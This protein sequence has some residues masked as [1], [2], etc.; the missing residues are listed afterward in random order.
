MD[1]YPSKLILSS[2]CTNQFLLSYFASFLNKNMLYQQLI[3]IVVVY[4]WKF[5]Q[6]CKST[7]KR[8]KQNIT[9]P[10]LIIFTKLQLQKVSYQKQNK[11]LNSVHSYV[12]MLYKE[13]YSWPICHSFW[14]LNHSYITMLYVKKCSW[15][16][17]PTL[18]L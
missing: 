18:N 1:Y 7:R 15:P 13:K 9:R 10:H 8:A 14:C 11:R 3:I 4:K 17:C 2:L 16:G 12:T 5:H 6:I